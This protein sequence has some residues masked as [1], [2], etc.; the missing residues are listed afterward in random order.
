MTKLTV[1]Q[2][3]EIRDSFNVMDIDRNGEITKDDLK[4]LLQG[5]GN[6]VTEQIDEMIELYDADGD[7]IIQFEEF[8]KLSLIGVPKRKDPGLKD[9]SARSPLSRHSDINKS[10]SRFKSP[11][12]NINFNRRESSIQTSAIDGSKLTI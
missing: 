9:N 12:K 7:G 6:L 5:S 3:A 8:C 2:V 4:I 10:M 11:L 1:H